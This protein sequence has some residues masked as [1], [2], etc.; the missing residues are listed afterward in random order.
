MDWLGELSKDLFDKLNENGIRAALVILK[1]SGSLLTRKTDHFRTAAEYI[2]IWEVAKL[3]DQIAF[4]GLQ[5]KV[6]TRSGGYDVKG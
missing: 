5:S 6:S 2:G 3:Q 4:W 1:P